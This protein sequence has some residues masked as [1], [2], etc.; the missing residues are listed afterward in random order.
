MNYLF[1]ANTVV[2]QFLSL[3]A[4]GTSQFNVNLDADQLIIPLPHLT[5]VL[6][7]LVNPSVTE[8]DCTVFDSSSSNRKFNNFLVKHAL[9]N[10]PNIRKIELRNQLC[11]TFKPHQ[12]RDTL[13]VECF[14]RSWNNL[15]SIK[16]RDDFICNED[17]LK[18]IQ[19]NFPNI[20]SVYII[21][22]SE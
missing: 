5:E 18:F 12:H 16:S 19:E 8:L 6:S 13:P 20:E 11:A 15:T 2:Q 17:T 14:K 9:Q 21:F 3:I 1:A 22:T 10:C 4:S 7:L